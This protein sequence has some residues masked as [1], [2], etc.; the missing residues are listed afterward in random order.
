MQ[1]IKYIC[2]YII[3]WVERNKEKIE[4]LID[5]SIYE[6]IDNIDDDLRKSMI[7]KVK[8]SMLTDF[9]ARNN[10]VEKVNDFIR[11]N[12]ESH[13]IS[14]KLY[15]KIIKFLET[16]KI[17]DIVNLL[18]ENNLIDVEKIQQI[19]LNRW[20]DSGEEISKNLLKKQCSK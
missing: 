4:N 3:T 20:K 6:T 18:E 10:I 7:L 17:K 9:S 1:V 15:D 12:S 14:S 2:P 5:N 19:I 16:T 11:N 13:E 8:D